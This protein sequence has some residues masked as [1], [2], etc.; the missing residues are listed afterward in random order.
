MIERNTIKTERETER[1]F[2]ILC[3]RVAKTHRIPYFYRALLQNETC[4]LIETER[5]FDIFCYR[6][7]KTH[8]I[9][10]FHR[11]FSAKVTYI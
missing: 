7:A 2:E 9:P 11:L 4:N 5:E 6:V 8:R 3:Y 10:Y 1:E